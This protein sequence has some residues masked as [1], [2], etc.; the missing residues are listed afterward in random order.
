MAA[1]YTMPIKNE[2]MPEGPLRKNRRRLRSRWL[3]SDGDLSVRGIKIYA[4]GHTGYIRN[5]ADCGLIHPLILRLES[6]G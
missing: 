3:P 6:L 4:H 1:G 5:N 2:G